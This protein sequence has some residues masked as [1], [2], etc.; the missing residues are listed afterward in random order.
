[1]IIGKS[2]NPRCLKN[3]NFAHRV[4]YDSSKRAWVTGYLFKKWLFNISLDLAK[5]KKKKLMIVDSCPGHNI[6]CSVPNIEILR[7][8]KNTTGKLQPMDLGII[9][10]LKAHF[11]NFKLSYSLDKAEKGEDV[12][13][14]YKAL[15]IRDAII[16]SDLAWNNVTMNNCFENLLKTCESSTIAHQIAE[17]DVENGKKMTDSS[18]FKYFI[19]KSKIFDPQSENEFFNTE[20]TENDMILYGIESDEKK[21]QKDDYSDKSVV[22]VEMNLENIARE[23]IS[24]KELDSALKIVEGYLDSQ[25]ANKKYHY[26]LK[27]NIV[28]LKREKF[29]EKSREKGI[30]A[31]LIKK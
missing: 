2:K 5:E 15:T 8:P 13:D 29:R 28:K 31:F 17:K 9:H 25:S 27:R 20:Y 4:I 22:K 24:D 3:F 23:K 19:K 12:Y 21:V 6:D 26:E 11:N 1:M 7:L 30:L 10:S 18:E 16:F 14:S